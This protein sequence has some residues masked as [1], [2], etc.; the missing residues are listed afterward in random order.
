M[1]LKLFALSLLTLALSNCAIAPAPY[2]PDPC[3]LAL[4]NKV[5]NPDPLHDPVAYC[6]SK[7]TPLPFT[8]MDG[9]VCLDPHDF[10]QF[11]ESIKR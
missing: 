1:R 9:W 11:L 8:E 5:L 3:Y 10:A 4:R 6:S 7:T 2:I